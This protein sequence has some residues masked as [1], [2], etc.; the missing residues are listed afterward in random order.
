MKS[1]STFVPGASPLPGLTWRQAILIMKN[2]T[3]FVQGLSYKRWLIF[4]KIFLI[5]SRIS[6]LL[7]PDG[8]L[9]AV[10][11]VF[12][13]LIGM[14]SAVRFP[15]YTGTLVQKAATFCAGVFLLHLPNV[16]DVNSPFLFLV[17][18]I[19]YHVSGIMGA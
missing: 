8:S 17:S 2:F 18:C 5:L 14:F 16:P 19:R 13:N 12:F 11:L 15:W 1:F 3:G 6:T 10:S 4:L 9:I 7:A